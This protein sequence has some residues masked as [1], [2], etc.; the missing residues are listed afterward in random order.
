MP[1]GY[2]YFIDSPLGA[3]RLICY[4]ILPEKE[5]YTVYK[6]EVI[7]PS[8]KCNERQKQKNLIKKRSWTSMVL[9]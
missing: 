4:K 1:H 3:F 7:L 5:K 2:I 6:N 9:V 8:P